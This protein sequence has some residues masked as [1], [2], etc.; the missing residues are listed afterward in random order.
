MRA[1]LQLIA[2]SAAFA[3]IATAAAAQGPAVTVTAKPPPASVNHAAYAF[4]QGITILPDG[5]S[6]ARWKEPVCPLVT[7]LT[8]AQDVAVAARIDQIALAAG[9]DV[10]GDGCAANFIV[11]AS[12]EPGP[13]LA[14]WRKRDP[15][16]FEG[17]ATATSDAF[18]S[19]DRPVR[20]WYD[21]DRAPAGGET[22]TTDAGTY[23]G[24]PSIHVATLSR[25]KRVMVRR[26][27][28]V[29][30]V[31]DTGQAR[32]RTVE[33]IADYVAVAGLAEIKLDADLEGV[34]SILRLFS[35]PPADQPAGLTDWDRGFLAGLYRSD[36]ASPLQRSAIAADV[37]AAATQAR[38]AF[39]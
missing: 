11:I 27:D 36:Q 24:V 13:L 25:L 1:H 2:V 31:V 26:I 34:P 20:V 18:V 23:Q 6:L 12:S 7:G 39:R 22:V 15:L 16:M 33:Q 29:I 3:V 10:G 21:V 5:E 4:V 19:K 35:A 32:G 9:A 14:A 37:T 38:G 30:L 8:E 17:S 28:M